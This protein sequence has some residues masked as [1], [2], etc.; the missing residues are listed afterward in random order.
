M[1]GN[2]ACV[3]YETVTVEFFRVDGGAAY[4]VQVTEDSGGVVRWA[5]RLHR[6]GAYY[7][8]VRVDQPREYNVVEPGGVVAVRNALECA[9]ME[10]LWWHHCK[11]LF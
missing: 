11:N 7:M 4:K 6:K 3:H 1:Q 2:R 8:R 10:A 5:E 9:W